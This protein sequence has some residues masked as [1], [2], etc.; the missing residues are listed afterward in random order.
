MTWEETSL[1]D[2]CIYIRN[3]KSVKQQKEPEGLPITRIETI[4]TGEI[5]HTRVGYAGFGFADA[6]SYLLKEGD[7]LFSH[8]NSLP[9]IGKCAIYVG[10]P[11]HIVHGMNLL[12]LR[13]DIDRVFPKYLLFALRTKIVNARILQLTN[14]AVNQASISAT[15]LKSVSIPLPPLAEQRRIAAIL[16]KA[17]HLRQLRRAALAKL[18][19]LLQSIFL[20][21]FGDP[22]TN[23]KRWPMTTI[24]EATVVATGSTPS[25]KG[26]EYYGGDIPWVKTTEIDWGVINS[27][28]ES[29][30]ELGKRRGRL[31]MYPPDSILIAMYGQGIT[32]GK[33]ARLGIHATV[34]QACAVLLPSDKYTPHY[35]HSLLAR[36]YERLRDMGQG[37]NQPNLNLRLVRSFEFPLPPLELQASFTE[38]IAQIERLRRHHESAEDRT[39]DLFH[40]LQQRA[41]RGDL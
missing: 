27:T 28:E 26:A 33:S 18:D 12:C 8:I 35:M 29:V 22:V 20:D 19:T 36:S 24:G 9:H 41:F 25:R 31:T 14:K 39:R 5:D 15:N 30:T 4:A 32:R 10:R 13:P 21:L 38:R 3:G 17:D 7:I 40:S 37:G 11:R 23:P 2:V 1:G 34:N 16:D 6:G